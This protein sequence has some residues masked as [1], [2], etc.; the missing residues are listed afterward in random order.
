MYLDGKSKRSVYS[1]R[2]DERFIK[3]QIPEPCKVL[4]PLGGL[5]RAPS[6]RRTSPKRSLPGVRNHD[7][8][9]IRDQRTTAFPTPVPSSHN[10]PPSSSFARQDDNLDCHLHCISF[11]PRQSGRPFSSAP[12][13]CPDRVAVRAPRPQTGLAVSSDLSRSS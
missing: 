2:R 10:P 5:R 9:L 7:R 6:L 12:C 8:R 1:V 11:L 4:R 13:L 3:Q